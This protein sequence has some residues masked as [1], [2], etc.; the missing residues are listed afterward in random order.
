MIGPIHQSGLS[1]YKSC[2]LKFKYRYIDKI[3]PS[4]QHSAALFGTAIHACLNKML[5]VS[6][7]IDPE[8][9][10]NKALDDAIRETKV[11]IFWK[12]SREQYLKNALEILSEF[13]EYWKDNPAKVLYSEVKFRCKIMNIQYEGIIDL[14]VLKDGEYQL[15]DFKTN[16][17]RPSEAFLKQSTQLNLYAFV[18]KF[19]ELF[20]DDEWIKPKIDVSRTGWIFLRSLERYKRKVPGHE[21]GDLKGE[22]AMLVEH[23]KEDYKIFKQDLKNLLHSVLKPYWWVNENHC[24]ICGFSDLCLSRAEQAYEFELSEQHRKL[25]TAIA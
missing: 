18:L 3:E 2:P 9:E 4:V 10:F 21:V 12:E 7:D 8:K 15:L 23:T 14:V 22:P 24:S 25:I 16:K 5:M 6:L 19:G 13:R 11:R 1:T 17:Q 20:V